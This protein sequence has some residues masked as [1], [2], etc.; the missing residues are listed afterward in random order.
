VLSFVCMCALLPTTRCLFY[1]GNFRLALLYVIMS[2]MQTSI[3]LRF[4]IIGTAV[5]KTTS[6]DVTSLV[7]ATLLNEHPLAKGPA[8]PAFQPILKLALSFVVVHLAV[9]VKVALT[10]CLSCLVG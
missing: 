6:H 9:A 3:C 4:R 7:Q 10:E 1:D 5:N 2:K 8:V